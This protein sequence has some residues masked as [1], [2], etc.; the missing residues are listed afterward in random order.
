MFRLATPYYDEEGSLQGVV[1]LNYNAEDM[2][3]QVRTAA[4]SSFGAVFLLNDDGYWL[5]NSADRQKEWAFMYEDRGEES[6]AAEFP[7]GV[8][9]DHG[10]CR[11]RFL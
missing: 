8:G 4:S 3:S 2:L 11:E 10:Q 6:F 5:Y 9:G 1:V 7:T